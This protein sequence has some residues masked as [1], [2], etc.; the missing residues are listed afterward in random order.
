MYSRLQKMRRV[1]EPKE[2]ISNGWITI[3]PLLDEEENYTR[4]PSKKKNIS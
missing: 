3:P 4:N 1:S 2:N